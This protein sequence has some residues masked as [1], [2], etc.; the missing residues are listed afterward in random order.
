MDM[1]SRTVTFIATLHGLVQHSRDLALSPEMSDEE[2]LNAL[3][4][5]LNDAT[6]NTLLYPPEQPTAAFSVEVTTLAEK[7]AKVQLP[8]KTA[9]E[10][11]S[12]EYMWMVSKLAH[13]ILGREMD[14]AMKHAGQEIADAERE[15]RDA[16]IQYKV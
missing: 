7:L 13:L 12:Y 4:L 2:K 10:E 1:F 3:K 5:F 6:V 9:T 16:G 11:V 15:N 14:D 8:P